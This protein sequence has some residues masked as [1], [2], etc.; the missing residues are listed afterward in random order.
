MGKTVFLISLSVWMLTALPSLADPA[1]HE[2][3]NDT[4]YFA[5]YRG[6]RFEELTPEQKER[7][8]KRREKFNSLP[9]EEQERIKKAREKFKKLPPEE[10]KK[11]K[12]KWKKM[13]PQERQQY[14]NEKRRE[15][16]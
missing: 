12:E 8:R 13:T 2:W 3:R 15:R 5:E 14:R 11:L 7:I 6:E 16:T 10:R 9:P 4:F 1:H